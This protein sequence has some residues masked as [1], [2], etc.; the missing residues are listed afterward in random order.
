MS[1]SYSKSFSI[2]IIGGGITG[3][4]LAIALCKRG[5]SCTIYEQAAAF[6]EIGAGVGV[7]PNAVRAMR[8]CDE[9]SMPILEAHSSPIWLLF[10]SLGIRVFLHV[11]SV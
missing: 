8:I 1:A 5:I 6:G 2:A 11:E 7:H 9:R 3:L 4:T 10:A